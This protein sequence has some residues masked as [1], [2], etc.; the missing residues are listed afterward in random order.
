MDD[1]LREMH[2]AGLLDGR[3]TVNDEGALLLQSWDDVVVD[4]T[5]AL[6]AKLRHATEPALVEMPIIDD[7]LRQLTGPEGST[8][9]YA[10]IYLHAPLDVRLRRNRLRGPDRINEANLRAMPSTI[11]VDLLSALVHTAVMAGVFDST[12]ALDALVASAR[13]LAE[14]YL[15]IDSPVAERPSRGAA[16]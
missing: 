15:G 10:L 11:P 4:A 14:G 1:L 2:G 9:R 5:R 12:C 3:A 7:L 13:H 6:A 8:R 16:R